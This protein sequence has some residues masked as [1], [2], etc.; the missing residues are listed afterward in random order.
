MQT[1]ALEGD[2][3][4]V[5]FLEKNNNSKNHTAELSE[6]RRDCCAC[7]AHFGEK[8]D[9]ENEQ[10]VKDDID[11]STQKLEQHR[12][13]HIAGR[14]QHLFDHHLNGGEK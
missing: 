9:S 4:L 6:Y 10:R 7:Y 2:F 3:D 12:V 5:I 8:A 13:N 1:E 11:H 14:L